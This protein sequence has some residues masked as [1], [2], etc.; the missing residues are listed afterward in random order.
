VFG[1][2]LEAHA[3]GMP[4]VASTRGATLLPVPVSREVWR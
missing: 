3:K 4:C 2:D 1:D